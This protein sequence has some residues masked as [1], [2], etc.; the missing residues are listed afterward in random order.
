[1]PAYV[2][3][4]SEIP[5]DDRLLLRNIIK[6]PSQYN[7][8]GTLLAALDEY[9]KDRNMGE[10][11]LRLRRIVGGMRQQQRRTNTLQ[12]DKDSSIMPAKNKMQ[13]QPSQPSSYNNSR[14]G[15]PE[16]KVI[17]LDIGALREKIEESNSHRSNAHGYYLM[18]S[19]RGRERGMSRN[20]SVGK[21]AVGS[22]I[23]NDKK[24]TTSNSINN[25][26]NSINNSINDSINDR[27]NDRMSS[28]AQLSSMSSNS[29][30]SNRL[31]SGGRKIE[32]SQERDFSKITIKISSSK[33]K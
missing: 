2:L 16:K 21:I 20:M 29:L 5:Y 23:G 8:H 3:V 33:P 28:R 6:H 12:S 22:S 26:A 27:I 24:D 4:H 30:L 14:K 32:S 18:K 25:G 11:Q 9:R 10:L 31:L 19:Q 13:S 7:G 17:T 15:T 1:M